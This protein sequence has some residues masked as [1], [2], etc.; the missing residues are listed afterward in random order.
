[1]SRIPNRSPRDRKNKSRAEGSDL[2][3]P[4][5]DRSEDYEVGYG[6]PPA[7]TRFVKGQSG[8]P[9]GRPRKPKPRPL[10]LSDAPSDGFLETEAYRTV[11]LRENGQEIE[12]SATQAVLRALTT[13]AIKGNRLSQKYYLEHLAR[14]EEQHLRLNAQY[15]VRLETLKHDGE[16]KLAD[17][18]RKGLP[19]PNLLPHPDDIVLNAITG[20]A[21]INGPATPEE[22]CLYDHTVL[23]RD[24]LLLRAAHSD[25]FW[26]APRTQHRDQIICT[27]L[28][29][30]QCLDRL[31]PRRYRWQDSAEIF[32]M[33]EYQT[34][35][36]RERERRIAG[37]S[38]RLREMKPELSHVTQ[39]L[40]WQI[41]RIVRRIQTGKTSG[42]FDPAAD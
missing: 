41:D 5:H 18:Q 12:L 14:A 36:R 10:R 40:K 21:Y 20:E 26:K 32:L 33:M 2:E 13:D 37:E 11:R 9:H 3:R 24:H 1:M 4:G 23:F 29:F 38:A 25:G 31:L 19:P 6:K 17:C 8:N 27:E 28:T 34:M 39:E 42:T 15:Y 30:A 35:T 22:A 16:R 7:A